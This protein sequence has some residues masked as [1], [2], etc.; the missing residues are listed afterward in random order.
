[1]PSRPPKYSGKFLLRLPPALH[2]ALA[3]RAERAATSLN[4]VCIDL[5]ST[6]LDTPR[7]EEPLLA[8]LRDRFGTAL[9]AIVLFGSRA[10]GTA[11]DTSDTDLLLVFA[12]GTEISRALYRKWEGSP[13]AMDSPDVALHCV[14]PADPERAGGLWLEM[15]LDGIVLWDADGTT[16]RLLTNLKRRIAEGRYVREKSHGHGYWRRVG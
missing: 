8:R 1:M 11:M 13:E 9:R 2:E 12:P 7:P 15:A 5:L 3:D 16:S 10:R 14:T 6:A 4:Q